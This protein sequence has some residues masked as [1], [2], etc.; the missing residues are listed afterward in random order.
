L[1]F[2]EAP[3]YI[4]IIGSK[5]EA[6]GVVVVLSYRNVYGIPQGPNLNLIHWV[7]YPAPV[8]Y[9]NYEALARY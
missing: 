8:L 6:M 7:I 4:D 1:D 3:S 5:E 2:Q 9:L